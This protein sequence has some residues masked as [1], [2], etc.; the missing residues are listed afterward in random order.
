MIISLALYSYYYD[1]LQVECNHESL[2]T[3]IIIG[4]SKPYRQR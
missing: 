2:S 4:K 3:N 1:I